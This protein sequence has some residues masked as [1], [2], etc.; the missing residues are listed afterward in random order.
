MKVNG[1]STNLTLYCKTSV[2]FWFSLFLNLI[3]GLKRKKK[4]QILKLI[5]DQAN[6]YLVK[7]K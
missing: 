3:V 2:S 5:K 6:I 1:I 7:Y 4:K